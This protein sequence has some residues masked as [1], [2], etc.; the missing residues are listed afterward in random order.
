MYGGEGDVYR[1]LSSWGLERQVQEQTEE[2][3]EQLVFGERIR[4][5]G[6]F[7][8]GKLLRNT[9]SNTASCQLP[10]ALLPLPLLST[11]FV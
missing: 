6:V 5:D 3:Q 11:S 9:V 2:V 1:E 7:D 10:S 8:L 4:G